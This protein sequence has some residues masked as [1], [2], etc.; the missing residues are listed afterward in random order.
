MGQ[1]PGSRAEREP[2][3]GVIPLRDPLLL[4]YTPAGAMERQVARM[5]DPDMMSN[6]L[7]SRITGVVGV[8]AGVLFAVAGGLKLASFQPFVD[9]YAKWGQPRWVFFGSG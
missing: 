9:Y 1:N 3:A 7:A 4:R 5:N 2:R 6:K 8:V